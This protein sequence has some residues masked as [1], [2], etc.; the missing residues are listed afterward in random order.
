MYAVCMY[1]SICICKMFLTI[2]HYLYMLHIVYTIYA[3]YAI[4]SSAF[5]SCVFIYILYIFINV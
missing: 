2:F 5:F 4:N 1:N 3:I